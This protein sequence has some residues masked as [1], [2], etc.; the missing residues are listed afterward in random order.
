MEKNVDSLYYY[1]VYNLTIS[2][3]IRMKE[4]IEISYPAKIDVQITFS[5]V[6]KVPIKEEEWKG[7]EV[8]RNFVS[9]YY[10]DV[11]MYRMLKG[12]KIIVDADPMAQPRLVRLGILS[13]AISTI[14]KQKSLLSLHANAIRIKDKA[15]LFLGEKGKGKST[16]T[17]A[18]Y[19][20]GYS[21]L[22]DDLT[23]LSISDDSISVLPGPLTLKLWPD[24]AEAVGLDLSSMDRID[25]RVP[26]MINI[27]SPPSRSEAIPL[28]GVFVLD[29]GDEIS[30]KELN[31]TESFLALHVSCHLRNI[32]NQMEKQVMLK[33]LQDCSTVASECK[34]FRLFRPWDLNKLP[35]TIQFISE[36][37]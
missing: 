10:K 23:A 22:S 36:F 26:K 3:E 2:S 17:A 27:M 15:Y 32:S 37:C 5:S 25:G 24:S 9:I 1:T 20:N 8:D 16:L 35:N 7:I 14:L 34:F 4:L 31:P 6:G 33:E 19:A 30:A 11:A 21:V 18:F 28:G 13:L 29:S 12:R